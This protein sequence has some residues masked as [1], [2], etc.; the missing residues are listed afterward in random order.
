M[1]KRLLLLCLV[2]LTL[3]PCV[4]SEGFMPLPPPCEL[5]PV[6]WL[7]QDA[8][9]TLIRHKAPLIADPLMLAVSG[10]ESEGLASS[11][12]TVRTTITGEALLEQGFHVLSVSPDGQ[13]ILASEG[14]RLHLLTGSTLRTVALNLSR[15]AA[16]KR[17]GMQP[18]IRYASSDPARL[19]GSEGFRW[20]PDGKYICLLNARSAK[21]L[22]SIPLMLIDTDKA[23]MYSIKAYEKGSPLEMGTAMQGLFSPDSRYLYYTEYRSCSARLCRYDLTAETHELLADTHQMI[24][25]YPTLGMDENGDL[26]SVMDDWDNALLTF[27]EGAGG[28]SFTQQA[29]PSMNVAYFTASG[30]GAMM[31]LVP[32]GSEP[33]SNIQLVRFNG[34]MWRITAKRKDNN[35]R[36]LLSAPDE[37]TE[38]ALSKKQEGDT[39]DEQ[40]L[41]IRHIAMSPDGSRYLLVTEAQDEEKSLH[42][43]LLG[44]QRDGPL[45]EVLLPEGVEL[46]RSL[47]QRNTSWY[48]SG[49]AFLTEDLLLMPADTNVTQLYRLVPGSRFK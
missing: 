28:W 17:E 45:V 38:E 11:T 27:R 26:L 32:R 1:I 49:I 6:Q 40:A 41:A 33:T 9:Y 4:Q 18:S 25:A 3:L 47:L 23:E 31:E 36:F 44:A 2:W 29:L 19:V 8:E 34:R 16:N 48:P 21:G 10:G 13:R 20:S 42:L 15:C 43:I 7:D 22:R 46:P 39:E 12:D 37:I 5:Q 35:I 24:M 30:Q 14:D